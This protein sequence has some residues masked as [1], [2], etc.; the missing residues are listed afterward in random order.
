MELA[1]LSAFALEGVLRDL[2][3]LAVERPQAPAVH[4]VRLAASRHFTFDRAEYLSPWHDP[5]FLPRYDLTKAELRI[6]G[7]DG[8]RVTARECV[9]RL[10]ELI[11]RVAVAE[12]APDD[13][14]FPRFDPATG[15]EL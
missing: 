12:H 10:R 1:D 7:V 3:A 13:S 5:S 8:H 2:E 11:T 15:A 14:P 4:T 9:P 6:D